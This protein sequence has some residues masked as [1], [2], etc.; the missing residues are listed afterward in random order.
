MKEPNETSANEEVK[1]IHQFD[2]SLICEYFSLTDR[3]G[4]GGREETLRAWPFL[5]D[6]PDLPRVADVGCGC[7]SSALL[8]AGECGAQVTAVDLFPH[9][10]ERMEERAA[11]LGI[12]TGDKVVGQGCPGIVALEADM[13]AL[14][15]ADGQFDVVWS[16]G[17]GYN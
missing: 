2:F 6:L 9:F 17:A 16:E 4:P 14:P 11:Q 8:L 13:A 10:L 7:G 5:R 1:N 3:L 15:F 12:A